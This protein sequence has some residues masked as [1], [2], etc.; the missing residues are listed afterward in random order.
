MDEAREAELSTSKMEFQEED[1]HKLRLLRGC[2]SALE[3]Q[4]AEWNGQEFIDQ[5]MEQTVAQRQ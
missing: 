3:H 4:K 2:V 5:Q 1:L